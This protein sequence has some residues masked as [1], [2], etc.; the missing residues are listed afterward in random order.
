MANIKWGCLKGGTF[1]FIST[2]KLK[3]GE[4][5]RWLWSTKWW[6]IE[7]IILDGN[8][9]LVRELSLEPPL[10]HVLLSSKRL[11]FFLFFFYLFPFSSMKDRRINFLSWSDNPQSNNINKFF[12]S[13]F[14]FLCVNTLF[15][16]WSI[17]YLS[18]YTTV[19]CCTPP[20]TFTNCQLSPYKKDA[21]RF[22]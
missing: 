11:Q 17:H 22:V 6:Y 8:V 20:F 9:L 13:G 7:V 3:M 19:H 14:H 2:L 1:R 21:K 5:I 15:N 16:L 12:F 18:S 4:K 10:P